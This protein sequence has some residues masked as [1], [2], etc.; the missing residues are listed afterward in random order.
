M[1]S[2]FISILILLSFPIHADYKVNGQWERDL[3][4]S[5]TKHDVPWVWSLRIWAEVNEFWDKENSPSVIKHYMDKLHAHPAPSPEALYWAAKFCR[6]VPSI[7]SVCRSDE[8]FNKLM[9]VDGSNL[10]SSLLYYNAYISPQVDTDKAGDDRWNWELLD[11]WLEQA[12]KFPRAVTYHGAHFVE[13]WE[14][15]QNFG[16]TNGVASIFRNAQVD[17]RSA[18]YI[19]RELIYTEFNVGDL[20][21]DCRMATYLGRE[22]TSLLCRQLAQRM[23]RKAREMD[24]LSSALLFESETYSRD[25]YLYLRL[26]RESVAWRTSIGPIAWCLNPSRLG[27][28]KSVYIRDLRSFAQTYEKD[29]QIAALTNAAEQEGWK[30]IDEETSLEYSCTDIQDFEDRRLKETLG[31]IDFLATQMCRTE[32]GCIDPVASDE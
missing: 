14:M 30:F 29:G 21:G 18:M 7:E 17:F 15:I 2:I 31:K 11:A 27:V 23:V 32:D 4:D 22:K 20:S 28:T 19:Y 16:S 5:I 8:L 1:K 6:R 13:L 26:A 9:Q 24:N 10:Y 3:W 12:I 25:E